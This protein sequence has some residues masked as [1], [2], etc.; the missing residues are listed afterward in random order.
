MSDIF[1]L[2]DRYIV[3]TAELD[4]MLATFWGMPGHDAELT[5]YSPEGWARRLELQRR[6]IRSIDDLGKVSRRDRIAADV[7]RERA[8]AE[9]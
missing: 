2:S 7:L 8:T 5:D 6:I 4:P 9:R 3:D 1:E